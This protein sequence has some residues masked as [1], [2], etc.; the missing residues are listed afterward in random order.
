MMLRVTLNCGSW[1][2]RFQV[3]IG[4]HPRQFSRRI[5]ECA[6]RG[7]ERGRARADDDLAAH[8]LR[9][10]ARGDVERFRVARGLETSANTDVGMMRSPT[11]ATPPRKI[12]QS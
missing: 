11:A 4:L 6:A 10:E 8:E 5:A 7:V 9:A 2:P 12:D 3:R 1:T